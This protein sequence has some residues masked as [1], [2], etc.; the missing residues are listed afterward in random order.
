[1]CLCCIT[2][3]VGCQKNDSLKQAERFINTQINCGTFKEANGDEALLK[4]TFLDFFEEEAYQKFLDDVFGYMYPQLF[5][6]TNA[7][8]IKIK[9]IKCKETIKQ[10]D[11]TNKYQ[12]EVNY[13]IIP[14]HKEGEKVTN[15]SMKDMLEI[16]V[17]KENKLTKVIILNT[18]DTIKKL[19][20][21]VKVQ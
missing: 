4:E 20:L 3:F 7:N 11:G 17:N 12:F 2:L 10:A 19:F 13:T 5:Y 1:M 14:I 21:D 8:E 6:I 16:T 15:I 18:S 9:K